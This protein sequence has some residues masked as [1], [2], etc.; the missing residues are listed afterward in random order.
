MSG[1]SY[2]GRWRTMITLA[3]GLSERPEVS[4]D[5]VTRSRNTQQTNNAPKQLS[6]LFR[7]ANIGFPLAPVCSSLCVYVDA[8]G[9][10]FI[11]AHVNGLPPMTFA[12]SIEHPEQVGSGTGLF[13]SCH[14]PHHGPGATH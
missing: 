12:A 2:A 7:K 6:R 14:S 4:H 9:R 8:I 11:H 13:E 3:S 5:A 1:F 10:W